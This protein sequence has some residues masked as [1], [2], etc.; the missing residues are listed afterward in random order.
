MHYLDRSLS[1]WSMFRLVK[2]NIMALSRLI[3]RGGG[4]NL[5]F[6][7]SSLCYGIFF[8]NN[9]HTNM[10]QLTHFHISGPT[11]NYG[12][13]PI[14]NSGKITYKLR[15]VN[16]GIFMVYGRTAIRLISII[17]YKSDKSILFLMQNMCIL[18]APLA[19]ISAVMYLFHRKWKYWLSQ[20]A[21]SPKI[22]KV[23]NCTSRL[24]ISQSTLQ[25]NAVRMRRGIEK[26]VNSKKYVYAE[27][28]DL[29]STRIRFKCT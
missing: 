28:S 16:F 2:N 8:K 23:W 18:S 12:P 5:L 29:K 1:P 25:Q 14:L 17:R 22:C 20:S 21:K 26:Y 4:S 9:H 27:I 10:S 7:Q 24:R 6:N 13:R 15:K 11:T 3:K 19:L